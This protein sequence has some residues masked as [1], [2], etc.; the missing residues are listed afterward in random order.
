[1]VVKNEIPNPPAKYLFLNHA[2]SPPGPWAPAGP[3]ITGPSWAEGPAPLRV[4][5][6]WFVYYDRYADKKYGAMRSRDLQ[7][8]EDV[9]PQLKLPAGLRHGTALAIPAASAPGLVVKALHV[10]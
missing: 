6:E 4:G 9:T 2:D 5:A 3:A 8:W 10:Q 7:N 1:M